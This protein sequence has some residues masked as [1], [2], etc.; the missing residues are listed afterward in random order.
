MKVK[1]V[2]GIYVWQ[3]SLLIISLQ[4]CKHFVFR[5]LASIASQQKN[6]IKNRIW[7]SIQGTAIVRSNIIADM[8]KIILLNR[9]SNFSLLINHT[10]HHFWLRQIRVSTPN[11]KNQFK[12]RSAACNLTELSMCIINIHTKGNKRVDNSKIFK[13]ES[14]KQN[15]K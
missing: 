1:C 12:F 15:I 10:W 2:S 4:S 6:R 8:T 7:Y 9:H 5:L 13:K 14:H 11:P 3:G